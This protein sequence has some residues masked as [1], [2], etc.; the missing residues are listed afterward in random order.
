MKYSKKELALLWL[1]GFDGI[2][3]KHKK[4]IVDCFEDNCD[5]NSVLKECKEYICANVGEKVYL[6]MKASLTKD[7]FDRFLSELDKREITGITI[8]SEYYPKELLDLDNYPLCLYAKGNLE[9]LKNDKFAIIGSRR[10]G[11]F[12]NSIA[13]QFA[14]ELSVGFTIV[15]GI[16][17]GVDKAVLEQGIKD[18][19][20]IC[21]YPCGFDHVYPA[22]HKELLEKVAKEGLLISEFLPT[23][24]LRNYMIPVRNRIFAGLS[25]GVLIVSGGKN[26]GTLWTAEFAEELSRQV[27]AI[28]YSINVNY[29]TT[30]NE[31]IKKGAYLTTE[32]KDILDFYGK[33]CEIQKIEL[34]ETEKKI[35]SLL[36]DGELHIEKMCEKLNEQVFSLSPILSMLEIKGVVVKSGFNV[37]GLTGKKTEA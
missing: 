21:V 8:F 18:K 22:T 17:E 31:L 15:A 29:G 11:E 14:S 4:A 19:N 1:D 10:G 27:F 23:V 16:S 6:S 3:Y 24:S 20:V 30:C 34:S 13:K 5:L 36:Q 9:L 35:V 2:E 7:Y 37:Y 28:P 26:S 12:P 33:E 32:P 25:K